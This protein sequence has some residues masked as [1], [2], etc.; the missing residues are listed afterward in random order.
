VRKEKKEKRESKR[1]GVDINCRSWR[2]VAISYR[3]RIIIDVIECD[4]FLAEVFVD[5]DNL[6][7]KTRQPSV[8]NMCLL[9][10]LIWISSGIKSVIG[11]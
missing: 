1:K 11:N 10:V 9:P 5:P 7:E 2:H 8:T 6:V 4:R 3:E